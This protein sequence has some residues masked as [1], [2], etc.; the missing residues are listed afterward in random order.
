MDS[1]FLSE[2]EMEVSGDMPTWDP[3]YMPDETIAGGQILDSIQSRPVPNAH[4][5]NEALQFTA[6]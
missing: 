1:S 6:Q 3:E 2:L 5:I 4:T